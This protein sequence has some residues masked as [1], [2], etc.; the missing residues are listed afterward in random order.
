MQELWLAPI[1]ELELLLVVLQN[2]QET[3]VLCS[4]H[5]YEEKQ[6]ET[7]RMPIRNRSKCCIECSSV[8]VVVACSC[9]LV[10][11]LLQT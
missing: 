6:L 2:R 4:I 9:C 1:F 10:H 7:G 3:H 5:L 8:L 11:D